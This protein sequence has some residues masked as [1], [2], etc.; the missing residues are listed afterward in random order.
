MPLADI[1]IGSVFLVTALFAV[2]LIV[3][4]VRGRL[5]SGTLLPT[6]RWNWIWFIIQTG[7]VMWVAALSVSDNPEIG[8]YGPIVVGLAVSFFIS[9][10]FVRTIDGWRWLR[11]RY[12]AGRGT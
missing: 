5:S 1:V 8:P 4:A 6:S 10:V 11:G 2:L 3:D 12:R 7:V 9:Y